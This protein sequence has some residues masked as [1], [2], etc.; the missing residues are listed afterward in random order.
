MATRPNSME[1]D[2]VATTLNEFVRDSKSD[3]EKWKKCEVWEEGRDLR[4][5]GD[6]SIQKFRIHIPPPL[7][8]DQGGLQTR[9]CVKPSGYDV[10]NAHS[11]GHQTGQ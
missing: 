10:Q 3:A 2:Q 8:R 11:I 5:R 4:A 9:V 7:E 6:G 1:G